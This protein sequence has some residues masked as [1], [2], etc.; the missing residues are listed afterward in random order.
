MIIIYELV[1]LVE[2]LCG[3]AVGP[4]S[5]PGVV[6]VAAES[7][8]AVALFANLLLWGS[9]PT[10]RRILGN[11]KGFDVEAWRQFWAS[12][13]PFGKILPTVSFWRN[14]PTIRFSRFQTRCDRSHLN[15][16]AS[17]TG[18]IG[19]PS[20]VVA[21]TGPQVFLKKKCSHLVPFNTGRT[22]MTRKKTER[23]L[24]C[25][26]LSTHGLRSWQGS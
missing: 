24:P 6:A 18:P 21:Q 10:L 19:T 17:L 2:L 3:V 25:T 14:H 26:V 7:P 4:K 12:Y 1:L 23:G 8:A 5:A 15:A 11:R 9:F 13:P 22:L 16:A 20:A